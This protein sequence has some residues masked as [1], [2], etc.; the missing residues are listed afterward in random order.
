MYCNQRYGGRT[1]LRLFEEK[2]IVTDGKEQEILLKSNVSVLFE[3]VDDVLVV[4]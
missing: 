2:E 1:A 4:R 3:T